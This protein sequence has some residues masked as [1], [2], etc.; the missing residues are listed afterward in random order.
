MASTLYD[1]IGKQYADYRR[2]DPRIAR[3]IQSE[4]GDCT[5]VVNIGAGS[6]SYEP[7]DREIVAIEP[8]R[9]MIAQRPTGLCPYIQARAEALPF[10]SDTFDCALAILTLHHWSNIQRGLAEARRVAKQRVVVSL[11]RSRR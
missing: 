11:R 2:P 9:V 1:T 7:I 10:R 5:S 8:S 6:G 3:A 4:I